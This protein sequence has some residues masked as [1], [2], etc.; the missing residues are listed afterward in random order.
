MDE[1]AA[2][3]S[4]TELMQKFSLHA[5]PEAFRALVDRYLPVVYGAAL[6]RCGDPTLAED[7][8]QLVFSDFA[9]RAPSLR[10]D[11]RIGAWLHRAAM[12]STGGL[13]KSERRRK[14]REQLAAD[15]MELDRLSEPAPSLHR[16]YAVKLGDQDMAAA[17][18]F[19]QAIEDPMEQ[20]LA[21]VKPVSRWRLIEPWRAEPWIRENLGW[22][23]DEI[24]RN[25][26]DRF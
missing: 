22:S 10:A 16:H 4:T 1:P 3:K 13:L 17:L 15:L 11:E 24:I 21:I 14:K 23:D 6:G 19:A 8:S 25:L 7:V 26:G 9:T 20:K 5:S 18:A 2:T 12:L